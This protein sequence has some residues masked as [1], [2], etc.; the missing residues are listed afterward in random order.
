MPFIAAYRGWY[1]KQ[2]QV[3][4]STVEAAPTRVPRRRRQLGPDDA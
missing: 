4:P 3:A 2:T 1:G